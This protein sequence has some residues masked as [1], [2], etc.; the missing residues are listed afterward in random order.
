MTSA[1]GHAECP[2]ALAEVDVQRR[3]AVSEAASHRRVDVLPHKER[4]DRLEMAL[5]RMPFGGEMVNEA[6][7]SRR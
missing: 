3:V 5:R 7:G 4:A 6:L 1:A 2:E